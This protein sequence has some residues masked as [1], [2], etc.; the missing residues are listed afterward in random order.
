MRLLV[1]L[2]CL[3]ILSCGPNP[4]T[5]KCRRISARARPASIGRASS[6]RP[7]TASR[8]ETGIV[9]PWPKDGLRLVWENTGC[10]RLR[11]RHHQPRPAVPLR[12]HPRPQSPPLPAKAKPAKTLWTFEYPTDYDDIYNY[13]GGPRCCPVVDGNRVYIYG[14]EGMLHCLRAEDGK[15]VWKMI[16]QRG[17]RRRAELLRRR[18]H[19]GDRGRSAAR[20]RSAAAPRARPRTAERCDLKSNGQRRGRLRQVHRQGRS[21]RSATNWPATRRP[22][23]RP[24][25]TAAGASCSRA[26]ACSAL[27]RPPVKSIFTIP[28]GRKSSKAS[29]PANPVVVGDQRVHLRDLWPGRGAVEGEAGRL[30]RK[31]GPTPTRPR[32]QDACSATGSRRFT[33]T[34]ISTAAAADIRK[35]R[36]CAASN[37]RRAR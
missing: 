20:R 17:F 26:A 37:W 25:A 34:A 14:A 3:L 8:P 7:P 5:R 31:C 21:T 24:S 29:T 16:R 1:S 15:V 19:A 9:A 11:R 10:R 27:I 36:S 35:T 30:A 32:Q 28:G 12:P 13:S 18:Q 23:W 22:C 33:W 2:S 4:A 6:D